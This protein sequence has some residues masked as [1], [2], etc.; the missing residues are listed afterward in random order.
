MPVLVHSNSSVRSGR[1]REH[2]VI[3]NQD[4]D[5][6]E[7]YIELSMFHHEE[8]TSERGAGE[9]YVTARERIG[10]NLYESGADDLSRALNSGMRRRR[11][12]EADTLAAHASRSS[13][14]SNH[15]VLS[16][17]GRSRARPRASKNLNH[18]G[19]ATRRQLLAAAGEEEE[20]EAEVVVVEDKPMDGTKRENRRQHKHNHRSEEITDYRGIFSGYTAL[21]QSGRRASFDD[22]AAQGSSW[23][24]ANREWL[25]R[26]EGHDAEI[27]G[28]S[29]QG[30][31][32]KR[33]QARSRV[34]E[35]RTVTRRS[36][37]ASFA[38]AFR[39]PVSSRARG[40]HL[41][42]RESCTTVA[43][44]PPLPLRR[45]ASSK[46]WVPTI[47]VRTNAAEPKI[48]RST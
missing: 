42:C 11:A 6:L 46:V 37:R 40:A 16:G 23:K 7:S 34:R 38:A 41:R 30:T 10:E 39:I 26:G 1:L 17:F 32:E 28:R 33:R 43:W 19:E 15:A 31:G 44:S 20:E 21:L 13:D 36:E 9:G 25:S 8:G 22:M 2:F 4:G 12:R 35:R 29:E 27:E 5:F 3:T 45:T 14:S 18:V 48:D 47:L 24:S